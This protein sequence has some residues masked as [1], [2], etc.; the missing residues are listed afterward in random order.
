MRKI[1]FL[2]NK[3]IN[4]IKW[5][6]CI[7]SSVN[8]KIYAFSWY[9]DIVSDTWDCLVYGNYDLVF[10][11]VV[12]KNILFNKITHPL[13]CQQLGPF[14]SSSSLLKDPKI[15]ADIITFLDKN[16]KNFEFAINHD[17]A[18]MF[19][20]RIESKHANIKYVDRI[21]LELNLSKDYRVIFNNYSNNTKRHL[22]KNQDCNF[23]I[24]LMNDLDTFMNILKQYVGDKA[25]LKSNHYS[26]I[27][28]L[29][30]IS[31]DQGL[32]YLSALYNHKKEVL[33]ISFIL[34]HQNRDIL[35]FNA[36][37]KLIEFNAMTVLV[38][39]YI[40]KECLKN[41]VLDFEG[42]NIPG[43]KRF[44]K[45]FGALERNYINIQK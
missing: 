8:S 34:T 18:Q 7:Q 37:T 35:L 6:D 24:R 19:K 4:R 13:F 22:K 2:C 41:K 3:E 5:D 40:Q 44:Y 16:Y 23:S 25:N 10:P 39:D 27:R 21:N 32:G 36:S 45:G 12:K 30:S 9:L 31:L 33:A 26:V 20:A 11:I 17:C 14:S 43:V 15:Y 1:K 28:D 42:S 29:I 38:D